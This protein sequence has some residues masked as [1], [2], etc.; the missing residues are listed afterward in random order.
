MFCKFFK[1]CFIDVHPHGSSFMSFLQQAVNIPQT[2]VPLLMVLLSVENLPI[3]KQTHKTAVFQT[4]LPISDPEFSAAVGLINLAW[5]GPPGMRKYLDIIT[6]FRGRHF[7]PC[8]CHVFS[9]VSFHS[10]GR[11]CAYYDSIVGLPVGQTLLMSILNYG[12]LL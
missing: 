2:N 3:K 8:L 1:S 9:R 11:S 7:G 12:E 4:F 6:L 5:C 10:G